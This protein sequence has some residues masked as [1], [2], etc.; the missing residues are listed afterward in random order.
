MISSTIILFFFFFSSDSSL[1]S[2][3]SLLS[4]SLSL[5]YHLVQSISSSL[6]T[7]SH[8]QSLSLTLKSPT[9]PLS[10]PPTPSSTRSK[11]EVS[12]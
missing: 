12:Q 3:L 4:K 8:C 1:A 5:S 11:R 10:Y 7:H 9:D 6:V 2:P